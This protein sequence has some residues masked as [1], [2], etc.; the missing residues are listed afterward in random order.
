MGTLENSEHFA[1][2]KQGEVTPS[3][4]TLVKMQHLAICTTLPKHFPDKQDTP[5]I[6]LG[7]LTSEHSQEE[8]KIDIGEE[9][10]RD[11]KINKDTNT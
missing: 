3:S 11:P 1:T 6:L 5:V 9:M 2:R 10:G 8:E 4:C 7:G